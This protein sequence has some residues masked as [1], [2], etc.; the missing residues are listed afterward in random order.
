MRPGKKKG[1]PTE[2]A[3]PRDNGLPPKPD[4]LDAAQKSLQ[5]QLAGVNVITGFALDGGWGLFV[6][7]NDAKLKVPDKHAGY[8]VHRRGVPQAGPA[9]VRSK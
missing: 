4:D 3:P 8:R 6:F 2:P 7:T 1:S 9:K 5:A